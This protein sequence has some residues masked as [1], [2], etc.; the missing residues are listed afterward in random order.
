MFPLKVEHEAVVPE[1]STDKDTRLIFADH[2]KN[3]QDFKD[4]Y[5]L[6]QKKN[7]SQ[8]E[9]IKAAHHTKIQSCNTHHPEFLFSGKASLFVH[10]PFNKAIQS[11]SYETKTH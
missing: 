9:Q 4:N 5:I 11:A 10:L 1:S 7:V 2:I 6:K 8:Y 3:T